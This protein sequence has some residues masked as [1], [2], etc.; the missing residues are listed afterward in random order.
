[1]A[2]QAG[3]QLEHDV[4]RGEAG[5]RPSRG[6]KRSALTRTGNICLACYEA[7][8]VQADDIDEAVHRLIQNAS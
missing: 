4:Q 1:M 6:R 7:V 2:F 3:Q 8:V 5:K